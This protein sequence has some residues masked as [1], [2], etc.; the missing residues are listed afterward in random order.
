LHLLVFL[1]DDILETS[2]DI[3]EAKLH[4]KIREGNMTAIIFF[5][6][7]KGQ[8]RGYIERQHVQMSGSVSTSPFAELS[9]DELAREIEK[10]KKREAAK[11]VQL[12]AVGEDEG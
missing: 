7:C 3:A 8:A 12:R 2:L 11:V 5:L 1:L 4:S 6:K 9:D 10:A